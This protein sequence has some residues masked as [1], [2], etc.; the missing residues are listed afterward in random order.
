ML[1]ADSHAF[2]IDAAFHAIAA[3]RCLMPRHA[4][5]PAFID[6]FSH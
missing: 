2:I 1:A 4:F 6:G 5:M 3:S